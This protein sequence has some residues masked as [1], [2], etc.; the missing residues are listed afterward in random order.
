[1]HNAQNVC[2][3]NR[4]CADLWLSYVRR[5]EHFVGVVG[6]Y[7][8][9]VPYQCLAIAHRWSKRELYIGFRRADKILL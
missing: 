9:S 8:E 3:Q 6:V 4:T 1:M 7:A 2:V 5:H